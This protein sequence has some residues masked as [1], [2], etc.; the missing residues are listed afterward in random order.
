MTAEKRFDRDFADLLVEL[1]EPEFPDYF[2][3]ALERAVSHRQRPAWTFPER[4]IPMG[5]LTRRLPLFPALPGRTVGI[6]LMLLL[7]LLATVVIGVG[8]LL[9]QERPAP[10]FGIASNGVIAYGHEGD[11][12]TRDLRTGESRLIVDGPAFDVGPW[13]SRDGTQIIFVRLLE[14]E[15]QEVVAVM[16]VGVDGSNQRTLVEPEGAG[17]IHWSDLSPDGRLFAVANSAEGVPRLS[18]VELASGTRTPIDLAVTATE[19][20]WTVDSHGLILRGEDEQGASALYHVNADGTGLRRLT[21]TTRGEGQFAP[22][23]PISHDGRYL[24]YSSFRGG[25]L[26]L[27]LLDLETD[28]VEIWLP[29]IKVGMATGWPAFSPDNELIAYVNYSQPSSIEISAQVMVGPIDGGTAAAQP[30]GPLVRIPQLTR[31]LAVQF[32]PDG[33]SLLI[34][35]DAGETWLADIAT[36]SYDEVAL[37]RD[38]FPPAWQR[39]AP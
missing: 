30:A 22:P 6:L 7:A 16:S 31:G 3:E 14:T 37:D 33:E 28:E 26:Y 23:F 9:L 32:S 2:Q 12:Y 35:S 10:P 27:H 1:A 39:R 11:I 13:F 24:A 36:R 25:A 18:V 20:E 38:E 5:V 8:A 29:P 21:E 15:P 19:F 4:W 17:E 34:T